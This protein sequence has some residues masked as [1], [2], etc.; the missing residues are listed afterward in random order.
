MGKNKKAFQDFLEKRVLEPIHFN[1]NTK[2]T[3]EVV[4]DEEDSEK[5]DT[6]TEVDVDSDKDK[7][8]KVSDDEKVD[9][10]KSD[11]EKKSQERFLTLRIELESYSPVYKMY[12]YKYKEKITADCFDSDVEISKQVLYSYA[13]HDV[14]IRSMIG[15]T[16]NKSMVVTREG[17][18][19]IA[20]VKVNETDELSRKI[21]DLVQ[22]KVLTS[23]SFI[24]YSEGVE[25]K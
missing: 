19:I 5:K 10:E 21:A 25:Y 2:A 3:V 12:E 13:D 8:E 11:T 1:A 7:E 4:D 14:S 23:N 9:D 16:L 24:F 17:N 6:D 22:S 15:S 20:R 18:T